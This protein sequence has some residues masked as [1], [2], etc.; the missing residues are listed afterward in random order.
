M[1]TRHFDATAFKAA[2]GRFP[3]GLTVVTGVEAGRPQGMTLQSFMSLSLDPRLIALAVGKSSTTW[4]KIAPSG[5]F[6]VNVLAD[7]QGELARRFAS[8]N[9]DRFTS[10]PFGT[11]RSGNP[12]LDDATAWLDCSVVTTFEIG[13]HMLV[14]GEVVE[15]TDD[16]PAEGPLVFYRSQFHSLV[17][18]PSPATN[19]RQPQ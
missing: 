11:A 2:V 13:D 3:T 18:T 8:R 9:T 4:P 14:V 19:E 16:A 6:A 7:S 17:P 12:V 15:L 10:A 5:S 1:D